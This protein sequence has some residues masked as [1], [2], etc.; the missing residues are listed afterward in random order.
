MI[1]EI[2]KINDND[3][4]ISV[5]KNSLLSLSRYDQIVIKTK[6]VEKLSIGENVFILCSNDVE[7]SLPPIMRAIFEM[8]IDW[9]YK[10]E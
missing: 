6:K 9:M 4:I 3:Y 5:E 2:E 1:G 10:A 8:N 7:E